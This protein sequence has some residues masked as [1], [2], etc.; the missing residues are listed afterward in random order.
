MNRRVFG[1]VLASMLLIGVTPGIAAAEDESPF[2]EGEPGLDAYAPEPTLDPGATTEMTVQIANSGELESGAIEQR[3]TVTTAR[4]VVVE[5]ED[6][7][8]PFTVETRKRSAGSIADGGVAE[9][10]IAVTVPDDVTPGKYSIDVVIEYTHT[11]RFKPD[12][13]FIQERSRTARESLDVRIDDRPR[14]ELR[15]VGSSAQIGDSGNLTAEV[16]N[17]G[18]ETARDLVVVLSSTT[19]DVTLGEAAN[20]TA[21]IDRLD[22]GESVTL[23]YEADVRSGV[24]PRSLPLLGTV[25]Y[26]D[27]DG[28]RGTHGGL[29]VGLR[30]RAEQEFSLSVDESTLRVGETGAVLGSIRN[31]GPADVGNA[32]LVVGDAPFEPRSSTYSI[33]DLAAGESTTFQFRGTVPSEADA[34]PQQIDVTTR[35]RTSADDERTSEGSVRVPVA[36]RRNAVAVA[37]I[38]PRFAAGEEGVLEVGVTNQRDIEIRD[39]QVG[40][41][42]EEPLV[43]EFRETVLPSLRPGE[44]GRVA[45]D[46]EVDG[47]A[48]ASR[49]PAIVEVTYLDRDAERNAAR[50]STVAVRVTESAGGDAPTEIAIFGVLSILVFVSAWWFYRR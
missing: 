17:V 20:N 48:P 29:S 10:P 33:G 19:R 34:V 1:V 13:D 26:T 41:V 5:I 31:D 38:E 30:P 25:R 36:D 4:S 47:D 45:F 23:P 21:R 8:V 28:I 3:E 18:G 7:A 46:L 27:P 12:S 35:Y 24:S 44:T 32:V 50:P 37:A 43:S 9:F 14:F 15:T 6:R 40:L 16:T 22:P 42:V 39:V 11:F 2:V 49:Y